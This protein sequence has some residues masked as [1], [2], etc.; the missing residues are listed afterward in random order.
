MQA[1][2]EA[3]KQAAWQEE[4]KQKVNR[5]DV[6][7]KET[8]KGTTTNNKGRLANTLVHIAHGEHLE[9]GK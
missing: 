2:W 8:P 3:S 4:Q 1:M 5:C 6:V 7:S 9:E